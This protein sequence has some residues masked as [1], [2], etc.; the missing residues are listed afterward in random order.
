M[1]EIIRNWFAR[2]IPADD[3]LPNKDWNSS[4]KIMQGWD[5]RAVSKTRE[6]SFS[7]SPNSARTKSL[8]ETDIKLHPFAVEAAL[9]SI[10]LPVPGGPYKI[11]PDGGHMPSLWNIWGRSIGHTT[12]SISFCFIDLQPPMSDQATWG[13][14]RI[15]LVDLPEWDNWARLAGSWDR[16]NRRAV[17]II[18][19]IFCPNRS[20]RDFFASSGRPKADKK[21][22]VHVLSCGWSEGQKK[23]LENQLQIIMRTCSDISSSNSFLTLIC[24]ALVLET[25]PTS[26]TRQ[27]SISSRE[28]KSVGC[29]R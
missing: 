13:A 15:E 20:T 25:V 23:W 29:K 19:L 7:L 27:F 4:M 10:V 18:R 28:E 22:S 24:K 11:I 1:P 6:I 8:A 12:V 21:S 26:A 14:T 5:A 17:E 16:K 2:T 3:R 9:A